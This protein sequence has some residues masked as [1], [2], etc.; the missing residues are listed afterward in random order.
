M[1][2]WFQHNLRGAGRL[3][4]R[5]ARRSRLGRAGVAAI[6]FGLFA[7]VILLMLAGLVDFS[8]YIGTRIELEQA[9]RAGGQYAIVNPGNGTEITNHV[10]AATTLPL[11]AADVVVDPI[12]CECVDGTASL[13]PGDGA[14]APCADGIAPGIYVGINATTVYDPMFLDLPSL[15]SNMS[16]SQELILRVR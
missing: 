5:R 13:C 6:E 1:I 15:T 14:Y 11:V 2:N 16:V 12:F 8:M 9:L 3:R 7:P 4:G 10:L